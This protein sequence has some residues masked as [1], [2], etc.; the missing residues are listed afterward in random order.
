M[1]KAK[2]LI[3]ADVAIIAMKIENQL[4]G[5]LL[6]YGSKHRPCIL[7]RKQYVKE[8]AKPLNQTLLKEPGF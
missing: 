1:G 2:M 6:Y 8:L 7:Y 5:L 4:Q 3:V